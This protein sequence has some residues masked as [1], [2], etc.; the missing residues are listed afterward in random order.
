MGVCGIVDL[1][2]GI[3]PSPCG[4]FKALTMAAAVQCLAVRIIIAARPAQQNG[5]H[6]ICMA[7]R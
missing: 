7:G 1:W 3:S 6:E 4:H 2:G 5:E